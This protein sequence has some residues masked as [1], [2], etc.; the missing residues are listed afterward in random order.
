VRAGGHQH[1][2]R[3]ATSTMSN[4]TNQINFTCESDNT[5]SMKFAIKVRIRDTSG[6][7][8]GTRV[9]EAIDVPQSLDAMK[10][11]LI[12]D[13]LQPSWE[14]ESETYRDGS[15][16]VTLT[17]NNIY[18]FIA[19]KCGKEMQAVENLEELKPFMY[20]PNITQVPGEENMIIPEVFECFRD[21]P[22]HLYRTMMLSQIEPL[23]YANP[24]HANLMHSESS[25][26]F[27]AA[28][29]EGEGVFPWC[30]VD[31]VHGLS[32]FRY[33]NAEKVLT[34]SEVMDMVDPSMASPFP[35]IGVSDE[36]GV[37]SMT[38]QQLKDSVLAGYQQTNTLLG[39]LGSNA[40]FAKKRVRSGFTDFKTPFPDRITVQPGMRGLRAKLEPSMPKRK[41]A[42]KFVETLTPYIRSQL[43][44]GVDL[45]KYGVLIVRDN[46]TPGHFSM[47][48]AGSPPLDDNEWIAQV[49]T[50]LFVPEE[51]HNY[52]PHV[53]NVI[54]KLS[55]TEPK[56]F[57]FTQ[58][59]AP[60]FRY[61]PKLAALFGVVD[62][63][64]VGGAAPAPPQVFSDTEDKVY[65][66]Y[67]GA[68]VLY[69]FHLSYAIELAIEALEKVDYVVVE[70]NQLSRNTLLHALTPQARS[71]GI[72]DAEHELERDE[73]WDSNRTASDALQNL[74]QALVD[75]STSAPTPPPVL[76]NDIK[77]VSTPQGR[78]DKGKSASPN[79]SAETPNK[80]AEMPNKS[81]ESPSMSV[82]TASTSVSTAT[83]DSPPTPV[84][85]PL[86]SGKGPCDRFRMAM[87]E[88]APVT[89]KG[90]ARET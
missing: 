36:K 60:P 9:V 53:R 83:G 82:S 58:S 85:D 33:N 51:Y 48:L 86:L 12:V 64:L 40:I 42:K 77:A 71:A 55:D 34:D 43:K 73:E 37:S 23:T 47:C 21:A 17:V 3:K 84:P 65:L 19:D 30:L 24:E 61:F 13:L 89:R 22:M 76:G 46:L 45:S 74:Q 8:E 2:V 54:F 31:G 5:N 78:S 59:F 88:R 52:T 66:I 10:Q 50:K 56:N 72:E 27:C 15:T 18:I 32:L 1:K 79:K 68:L 81:E 57:E 49:N 69:H 16:K 29:A 38:I 62:V 20:D 87:A 14:K 44:Q 67:E 39:V 70:L 11:S 6:K 75:A 4:P 28:F 63:K 26:L 7:P 80:S 25:P 35:R 90:H 41:G